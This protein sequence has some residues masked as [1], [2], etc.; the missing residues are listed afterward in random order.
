[1]RNLYSRLGINQSSTPDEIRRAISSCSNATLRNDAE[2]VLLDTNR[3]R[4]Y[5]KLHSV[6]MDIGILRASLGHNH[7]DNWI[8]SE[9]TDYT[10]D[11]SR[12]HSAHEELLRKVK[13]ANKKAK[14]QGFVNSVKAPILGIFRLVAGFAFVIGIIWFIGILADGSSKPKK[15]TNAGSF[16]QPPRPAFTEPI[17][18]LPYSGFTRRYTSASGVAPLQIRTSQGSNYLVKLENISTGRNIVDI[19][20]RGGN[21]AEVKV[22]LGSYRIKYAA[23]DNWYGYKYYFGPTT[24]YSK[25]DKV[26]HFRKDGYQISGYTITLYRVANGNL[27]TSRIDPSQF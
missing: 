9:A 11:S 18:Q 2:E 27:R 14:T 23:G 16:S 24:G 1:M 20:I 8:G 15:S 25:A 3:R 17:L 4:I 13:S 21:T 7:A 6:L 22:P 26:F 10:Q 19:F 5:N 12:G